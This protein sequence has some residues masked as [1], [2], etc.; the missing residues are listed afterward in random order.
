MRILGIDYGTKRI[1]L[2]LSDELG[3]FAKEFDIFSSKDFFTNLPKLIEEQE[4]ESIVIGLPLNMS[5]EHSDKTREALEFAEK[6]KKITNL[7]V[8]MFDERLSSQMA[9]A[10]P[11]GKKNI[12]SLAAQIILQNF[13]DSRK[14]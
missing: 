8:D 2:A 5:G 11:G 1:G 4:I 14:N 7:K 3:M 6:L 13:L 12:D 9:E 10:L